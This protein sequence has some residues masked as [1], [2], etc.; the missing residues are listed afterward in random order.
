[1]VD[2]AFFRVIFSL[3]SFSSLTQVA[4]H[5]F[6]ILTI[7]DRYLPC[8]QR[9]C[10]TMALRQIIFQGIFILFFIGTSISVWSQDGVSLLE[11]FPLERGFILTEIR[12]EAPRV[13]PEALRAIQTQGPRLSQ[14]EK[15]R[16][17]VILAASLFQLGKND[18][19]LQVLSWLEEDWDPEFQYPEAALGRVVKASVLMRIGRAAEAAGEADRA[20]AFC[21]EARDSA[22]TAYCQN[23][24]GL[25]LYSMGLEEEGLELF[26]ESIKQY[27]RLGQKV[28][29]DGAEANLASMF[30]NNKNFTKAIQI[31]EKLLEDPESTISPDFQSISRTNYALALLMTGQYNRAKEESEASLAQSDSLVFPLGKLYALMICVRTYQESGEW[32][33]AK[34]LLEIPPELQQVLQ[35]HQDLR[36][37]HAYAQGRQFE[38]ERRYPQ[39]L[40]AFRL[41]ASE[42]RPA[43]VFP[44]LDDALEGWHRVAI[45]LG[46][47][48]EAILIYERMTRMKDSLYR[49]RSAASL[50]LFQTRVA[51][52]QQSDELREMEHQA[53]ISRLRNQGLLGGAGGLLLLILTL[54]LVFRFRNLQEQRARIEIHNHRL[55]AY[56]REL[57]QLAFVVSHNLR[58]TSRTIGNYSGLFARKLDH[59]LDE[60]SRGYLKVIRQA[61][62]K[63]SDMLEDLENYVAISQKLPEMQPVDLHKVLEEVVQYHAAEMES[64]NGTFSCVPLPT[65]MAHPLL[66]R[67]LWEELLSN[68][69]KYAGD[70]PPQISLEY[71]KTG[72]AHVILFRDR[73]IGLNPEYAP[74][75]FQLF[76]RLHTK[77]EI[78]GTGIGLALADK[79]MRQYQ[80]SI[81][82]DS[83][84]GKGATFIL[85]FPTKT[86][87]EGE[88]LSKNVGKPRLKGENL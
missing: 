60:K 37:L 19:A 21:L 32:A 63:T 2:I 82:V 76:Q 59:L 18:S 34:K 72:N 44:S 4:R 13:Y 52:E 75:I 40:A 1:M 46:E 61:A 11:E 78:S 79:I 67:T 5:L 27:N 80:G 12:K 14:R 41:A 20:S 48:E 73:G 42:A 87:G 62:A 71:R 58:E 51:L 49:E 8:E 36:S 24:E 43:R 28:L 29:A 6:R 69:I 88:V 56:N 54:V 68:A 31:L 38:H 39:A 10:D 74:K 26:W 85:E 64:I 53:S 25:A 7:F 57:E 55:E 30:I 65:I 22:N 23:L 50:E 16:L 35:V 77:D 45:Q 47:K 3:L 17:Q 66:I 81:S 15:I 86:V 33:T 83:E 70:Q 9:A 84:E